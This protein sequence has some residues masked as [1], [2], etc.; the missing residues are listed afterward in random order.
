M[1]S[2]MSALVMVI[3]TD[4]SSPELQLEA[5]VQAVEHSSVPG[6][7]LVVGQGA[8]GCTIGDGVG[9]AL[10]AARHRCPTIAIE[11]PHRFDVDV[12]ERAY[13][14]DDLPGPKAFVDDHGD[15]TGDGREPR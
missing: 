3:G 4:P 15:V 10:L 9:Q 7:D 1:R 2:T 13:F 12:A 6:I 5:A 8:V 11:Q 14:L